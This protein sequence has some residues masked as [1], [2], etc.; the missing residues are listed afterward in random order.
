MRYLTFAGGL[1]AALALSVAPVTPAAASSASVLDG[2][3]LIQ[4]SQILSVSG[5]V[6]FDPGIPSVIPG[7]FSAT[8]DFF[9]DPAVFVPGA[10]PFGADDF[11][12]TV[13][14]FSG[15]T[16]QSFSAVSTDILIESD[17]IEILYDVDDGATFPGLTDLVL[18]SITGA[19]GADP[20][21]LNGA[22]T[23][24]LNDP[25]TLTLSRVQAVPLPASAFLLLGGIAGLI[26][27]RRR[28]GA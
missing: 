1:I 16:P 15:L 26:L 21:G 9:A 12:L 28:A 7:T 19:F 6:S 22:P 24:G 4:G 18:L 13:L 25:A 11:S 8:S 17:E 23:L 3:Q 14:G 2:T 27:M 5:S 10:D 20:F